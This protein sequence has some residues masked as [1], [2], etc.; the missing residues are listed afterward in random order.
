MLGTDIGYGHNY[1]PKVEDR[2]PREIALER[3]TVIR[4]LLDGQVVLRAV[5]EE[6]ANWHPLESLALFEGHWSE[7]ELADI[8]R[9]AVVSDGFELYINGAEDVALLVSSSGGVPRVEHLTGPDDT[10]AALL[11]YDAVHDGRPLGNGPRARPSRNATV[12]PSPAYVETAFANDNIPGA[13]KPAR[14]DLTWFGDIGDSK[15]KKSFIK[16]MLGNGEFTTVS[17]LPGTGKSA[18]MTDAACHVAAAIDWQGRRVTSGLVV[19]IAAERKE[20]T[21]RRMLAFRKRHGVGKIP[22]LVI[23]GRF[24]LTTNLNDAR[25]VSAAINGAAAARGLPCVWVIMDTLTRTFGPGDQN[26]SKDMSR[27]IASCHEI[28]SLTGAHV[29][30]VHHTA[31]SGERGKGAIDLD[32]AIDASF[33]VKKEAGRYRMICDGANDGADGDICTFA[34]ESVEVGIDEDG[35]PTTAPVIVPALPTAGEGLVANM[36]GHTGK[37]L[38]SLR[39]AIDAEG[40]EPEGDHFPEGIIVVKDDAWRRTFYASDS[41]APLNTMRQRFNR[42]KT[43]LIEQGTIKVAG[44]WVW[45]L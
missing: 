7:L 16:G 13:S 25:A 22:L 1:E 35:E 2:D 14:F 44:Q 11:A 17:G 24:D 32:G 18:I 42:A 15:P 8:D 37:A 36:K 33:L 4:N 30:A 12:P 10:G 38:A 5:D 26:A 9:L 39:S 27:Y 29:T 31:W 23:G 21:E 3:H 41:A 6:A 19:F 43:A 34:M 40:V 45:V 28:I 20:L